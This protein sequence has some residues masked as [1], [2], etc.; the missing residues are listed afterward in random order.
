MHEIR[1]SIL[2]QARR[3]AIVGLLLERIEAI[4]NRLQ[5]L[6]LLI[7]YSMQSFHCGLPDVL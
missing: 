2:K 1:W 4:A 7:R 5:L 6:M 3:R